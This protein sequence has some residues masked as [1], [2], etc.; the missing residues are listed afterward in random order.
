M[1]SAMSDRINP[2]EIFR[3]RPHQELAIEQLRGEMAKGRKRVI[4][5]APCSFGKTKTAI[6][7]MLSSLAKGKRVVFIADRVKLVQQTLDA[8]DEMG[9]D[10]GVMQADHWRTD[11]RKPLQI[12]SSQTL[13]RRIEKYGTR[14]FDFDVA[15][16]DECHT[17]YKAIG[18]LMLK[19]GGVVWIG[20]TA[21]PYSQ[22]LGQFYQ[23]MVVP[24][25]TE[26]LL[27]Q[28]YLTPVKYYGGQQVDTK[29]IK[30]RALST[31]GYDFDPKAVGNA[32]DGNKK[33]TGSIIA[34]W[35][36]YAAGRQTI[37]FASSIRASKWLVQ[38]FNEAGIPAAH[39]DGYMD[40]E[41]RQILF[42]HHGKDFLILSCSQLLTVGYDSPP[43]SALID[44]RPTRSLIS[45]IQTAGRIMRTHPGK[46]DAIYLDHAGNINTHGF[47]ELV[48]PTELDMGDKK[49]N[50]RQLTRE[51]KEPTI[52][53]CPE[54]F[55]KMQG[56]RCQACGYEIPVTQQIETDNKIL[57]ELKKKENKQIT[58][59]EKGRFL[60]ELQLYGRTRGYKDGW[61]SIKYR[62][63]FGVWP[64]AITADSVQ[65]ISESTMGWLKH[66]QIKWAKRRTA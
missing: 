39:I 64:N 40:E 42:D 47:P 50:E 43:C 37:A 53:D 61:A 14:M 3:L 12:A 58:K 15:I 49:Y 17:V 31:G 57:Q 20:L 9:V 54:C 33:L 2:E 35:E 1:V 25:T 63:R 11:Y 48:V 4:L 44:V 59:E 32:V 46:E 65:E 41:E 7:I 13:T 62:E 22:G 55:Q 21:T 26:Q 19:F 10:V 8:A 28:G 60:G 18:E 36:R 24:I 51:K 23:S 52:S 30:A 16:V 5:A 27:E 45:F 66:Q 6:S 29:G 38:Q 34:N 56:I